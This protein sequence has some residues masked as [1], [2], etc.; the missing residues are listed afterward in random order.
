M[1]KSGGSEDVT[2]RLSTPGG[3]A[4]LWVYF[5]QV[6]GTDGPHSPSPGGF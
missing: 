6:G 4:F 2:R 5:S 1:A 3:L